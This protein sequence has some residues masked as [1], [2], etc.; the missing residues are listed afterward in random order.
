MVGSLLA[1]PL[2]LTASCFSVRKPKKSCGWSKHQVSL[3]SRRGDNPSHD[4]SRPC[5]FKSRG[6]NTTRVL[7]QRGKLERGGNEVARQ[8]AEEP[9][10]SSTGMLI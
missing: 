5:P 7:S 4:I 8:N 3:A 6:K 10:I 2:R 9:G 1:R